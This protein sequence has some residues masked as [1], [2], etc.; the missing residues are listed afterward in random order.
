V[1]RVRPGPGFARTGPGTFAI[2]PRSA[3]DYGALLSALKEQSLLPDAV[4]HLWSLTSGVPDS[5][6]QAQ[7]L[8]QLGLVFLARA[9]AT[10]AAGRPCALWVVSNHLH[11]VTGSEPLAPEKATLLGACRVISQEQPAL[12]CRSVDV[13]PPQ[14]GA[15]PS[16]DWLR[17]LRAEV[18][19]EAPDTVVALRG[20]HRWV[21][22]LAP[23]ALPEVPVPHP[24]LRDG[25][26]YLLVGGLEGAGALHALGLAR[27][28]KAKLACMEA[29]DLP[30]RAHW[31]AHLAGHPA[32]EP[33]SRRILRAKALEALGTEVLL[34]RGDL[35]S[36]EGV[37][38]AVDT[39]VARF[40]ALHGV[41]YAPSVASERIGQLA[42][43]EAPEEGALRLGQEARG[44]AM[45]DTVLGDRPLD[46]RVAVSSLSAVL[47]GVGQVNPAAMSHYLDAFAHA[48]FREGRR[49]LSL[50]WDELDLEGQG[51]SAEAGPKKYA[52]TEAQGTEVFLR[53]LAFAPGASGAVVTHDLPG[54][55]AR[56]MTPREAASPAVAGQGSEAAGTRPSQ[57]RP[58]LRNA[59][60]APGTPLERS[61]VELWQETLGV[62]PIG[63]LDNFFELGGDLP[64]AVQLS[65]RI[66]KRLGVELSALNLY[67]GVTVQA[68]T[69]LL[70][71]A[72]PG[73]AEQEARDAGAALEHRKQ[74]LGRQR[75]LRRAGEEE[76]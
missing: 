44:L 45:L 1:V 62:A 24:V 6:A 67:D 14:G 71:P 31:D 66:K 15:A 56:G 50:G 57:P 41:V 4:L 35:S 47:G 51:A 46:F 36:L 34:I 26:V 42:P 28:A 64:T 20:L 70:K 19:A 33:V 65:D 3:A 2:S 18:R 55:M 72:S 43:R 69:A 60:L 63:V 21:P 12:V 48:R 9:L 53:A 29:V 73:R 74:A 32:T 13:V 49:W 27:V 10:H 8:G 61:L 59:Y 16:E 22:S 23:L 40:G 54:R 58:Q 7:P 17:A 38:A 52:I 75:T 39:V 76:L 30:E 11:D 5:F 68:L 37:R 25:G